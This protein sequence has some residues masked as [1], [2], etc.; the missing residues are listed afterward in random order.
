MRYVIIGNAI[1]STGAIEAIRKKDE[2]SEII[3]IS[4]EKYF[5]YSRAVIHEYLADM[6]TEDLMFYRKKDFYEK[7]N[8][9][10]M[11]GKKAVKLDIEKKA[12]IL[13]DGES[14]KYDKLLI[15]TGGKPFIPPGIENLDKV[16]YFTFTRWDDADKLR[17][18][19]KNSENV[20]VL[21][22]GLIGLQCADGLLHMGKK[23]TVIELADTVLPMALDKKA[24]GMILDALTKEGIAFKLNNTIVKINHE[25]GKIKELVLKDGE[26]IPADVLVI[27]VGVIPRKDLAVDIPMKVDRGIIVNE[28]M[29]TNIP[30][31]YAAGDVAQGKE[32]I[33]GVKMVIPI[34]PVAYSQGKYAGYNMTG[35]ER[36]YSGSIPMNSLQFANVPVISYGYVKKD[37]SDIE[38]LTFFDEDRMIYKRIL[39]E[40]NKM[41]GALFVGAV[42]R[43]GIFRYIIEN[44][45]DVSS[46]KEHLFKDDFDYPYLPKKF[47]KDMWMQNY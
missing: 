13:D 12:V 38:E 11:L 18:E 2:N 44:K 40:N 5:V 26:T 3:V 35:T 22:A 1:A 34:I 39:L 36:V 45:L 23:T 41:I 24:S 43:V 14:V 25:N 46:F 7:N 16:E 10:T 30:D 27:A 47:R 6:V 28:L 15:A 33:S 21:G 4:D 17:D 19:V 9:T 31:V 29:E 37:D 20:V 8:V 42:D 32:L